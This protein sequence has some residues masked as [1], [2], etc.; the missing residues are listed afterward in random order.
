MQ[1]VE[2]E[3]NELEKEIGIAK[4]VL[5]LWNSAK[6]EISNCVKE[7]KRL[8]LYSKVMM[9]ILIISILFNLFFFYEVM[10]LN[11][12]INIIENETKAIARI[13]EEGF[14]IEEEEREII[15]QDTE[16]DNGKNYY[17]SGDGHF[18][19]GGE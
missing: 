6:D 17:Q 19:I 3:V 1:E 4:A 15:I 16:G 5:N 12:K 7:S 11:K 10:K 8:A 18:Y 13:F 2:K 9:P 14:T